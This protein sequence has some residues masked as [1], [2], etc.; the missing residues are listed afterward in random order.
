MINWILITLLRL[1]P[2]TPAFNAAY[3]FAEDTVKILILL[4]IIT[5]AMGLLRCY[6]PIARLRNFLTS[7]KFYGADYFLA[8]L[9]GTITPFCSCSS[10]PLFIGFLE[11]GIPLGITLAFL[12]TSP[13]INEVAIALFIGIFGWKVTLIYL[14]SGIMIGMIGGFVLGKMKLEKYIEPYVLQES[15]KSESG[16]DK[17]SFQE[18]L[19]KASKMAFRIF[20]K[21]WKYIIIGV[22][23]G[24]IVHGYVPNGFFEQ[25]LSNNTFA[26]PVAVILA[27]PM[28][29][30]ASSVIPILQSLVEKGIPL[31]TALAFMMGVVGLS[32]PEAVMLKKVMKPKLLVLFFGIVGLGMIAIGY[33]LNAIL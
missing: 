20:R 17:K 7:R 3:F 22:G 29:A 32:F 5:H 9:F 1:T 21:I 10:I 25:H 30:N 28:Y 24:A 26:V 16:N 18:N 13:L 27:I 33:G 31:G 12:I 15:V 4:L 11:A 8:T 19:K 6:L 2:E 23:I 14:A